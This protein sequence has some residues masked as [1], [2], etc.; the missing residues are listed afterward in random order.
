ML[1]KV[2]YISGMVA[3]LG[4]LGMTVPTTLQLMKIDHGL[5]NSLQ[6]TSVLVSIQTSIIQ[7]NAH[8]HTVISTA[9][10]MSERLQLTLKTTRSI[11]QNIDAINHLNKETLE[12]NEAMTKAAAN[13]GGSLGSIAK[14]MSALYRSTSMLN[15]TLTSLNEAISSDARNLTAMQ[16]DV[17]NMNT[18]TPGVTG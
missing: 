14:E 8:L 5:S 12:L 13:S 9:N 3:T 15:Q 1:K 6:A 7:K 16:Q 18:K 11:R 17:S 2:A 10:D 4:L